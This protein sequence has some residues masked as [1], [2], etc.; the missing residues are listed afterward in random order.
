MSVDYTRARRNDPCVTTTRYSHACAQ[1][2]GNSFEDMEYVLAN[3]PVV[4][5]NGSGVIKA[6]FAGDEISKYCFP[7]YVGRPKHVW[8]MAGALEGDIFIGPKTEE[9]RGLRYPMEHV[10][11]LERHGED[12][13][14]HLLKRPATDILRGAPCSADRGPPEST[15]KSSSR[16]SMFQHFVIQSAFIYR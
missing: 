2:T 14:V 3:Q 10:E 9:H 6:G 12:M 15:E 11:R 8:V 13:A 1:Q 7:N 16:P 4:I 5:N